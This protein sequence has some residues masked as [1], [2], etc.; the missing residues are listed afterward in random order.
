MKN[1]SVDSYWLST[2]D[3]IV[4]ETML[5]A[6]GEDIDKRIL[7]EIRKRKLNKIKKTH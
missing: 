1:L 7:K 3:D 6:F 4:L 5:G 2:L